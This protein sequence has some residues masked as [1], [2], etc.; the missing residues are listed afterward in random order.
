TFRRIDPLWVV[1]LSD[2]AN[3]RIAGELQVP[4]YSTFIQPLGDRLVTVG[5]D[6]S[7]SWRVAVS[8]FDVHDPGAPALLSNVALG[9]NSSWSEANSDEKAFNVMP[10]AGLIL[11]PYQGDYTNGYASRIQLIDLNRDSLALRGT[12]DHAAQPRRATVH[13]D[14]ILSLSGEEL[15]TVDA[16]DRD[17]PKIKTVIPLAWSVDLTFVQGRYLLEL[18]TASSWWWNNPPTPAIRITPLDQ[19]D[20]VANDVSL[21]NAL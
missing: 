21:P 7:N 16:P 20:Q 17:Q 14:R 19:P 11:L 18:S 9:Q 10:D 5:L 2:P 15:L 4:G 1:D 8:L 6:T 13:Q 3:P 12:I